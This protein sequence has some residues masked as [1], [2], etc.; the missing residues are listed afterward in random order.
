[1]NYVQE[2]AG[3]AGSAM[4][5]AAGRYAMKYAKEGVTPAIIRT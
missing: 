5:P 2:F 3:N 4:R 1:M